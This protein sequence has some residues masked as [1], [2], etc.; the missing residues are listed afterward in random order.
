MR[1]VAIIG[2][3]YFA[4]FHHEA[5]ARMADVEVVGVCDADRS[6][7]D[8]AIAEFHTTATAV[9][10][11]N[12]TAMLEALRPDV[13]DIVTPPATHLALVTAAAAVGADVMCQKPLAPTLE[14]ARAIV[15]AAAVAGVHLAIHE[16]FRFQPWFLEARRLIDAGTFGPMHSVSFR[17]RPGGGQGADAY[18]SR[19]SYFQRM[20]RFLVF[21]TAVHFID[22]FRML[23]G[24]VT[25]VYADLRRINPVIAGE[26]AG[27]IVFRFVGGA[28]GLFDGNRLNDHVA[29]NTRRTMGEMWLEGGNGVLRLNG[30]GEL[31]WK[32]HGEPERPHKYTW[33]DRSFAGDCVYATNRAAV[34]AWAAG[35]DASNEGRDYLRNAEL[36]DAI[37]RSNDQGARIA[38]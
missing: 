35:R 18:L 8:A 3:G 31:F 6:K 25:S 1:R 21:E 26:D 12:A 4:R 10:F 36:V 23:M 11:D 9:A 34:E 32:P 28:V 38:V 22:T 5:W 17:L 24:E 30:D 14:E 19:Q 13:V 20:P 27:H 15:D 37:Y 33:Q 2:C 29:E 7:A 16:N